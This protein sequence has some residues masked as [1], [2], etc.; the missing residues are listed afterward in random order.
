V[1]KHI[2]R[3]SSDP[4]AVITTYEGKHNHEV[5]A[6]RVSGQSSSSAVFQPNNSRQNRL[7]NN[8]PSNQD[9]FKRT[10][11]FSSMLQFKKENNLI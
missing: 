5:P 6:S 8:M 4:K 3:A 2:E 10:T 9:P 1:R 7:E 11:D